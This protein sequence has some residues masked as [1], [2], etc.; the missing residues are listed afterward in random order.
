MKWWQ[1]LNVEKILKPNNFFFFFKQTIKIFNS[2]RNWFQVPDVDAV[3]IPTGGGGLLAGCAVAL[4]TMKPEV[5]IIVRFSVC[6]FVHLSVCVF[7]HWCLL[8]YLCVWAFACLCVFQFAL[9]YIC[10]CVRLY[11]CTFVH[12]YV[13]SFHSCTISSI[14]LVTKLS[15]IFKLCD[16]HN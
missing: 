15:F 11:A 13:C 8:V 16:A 6:M 5:K 3:I 7:V 12:L 1:N 9:L 2:R 10:P 4:K 14:L